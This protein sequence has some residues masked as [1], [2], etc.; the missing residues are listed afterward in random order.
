MK[1][2]EFNKEEFLKSEL[3]IEVIQC[4]QALETAIASDDKEDRHYYLGKWRAYQDMLKY[5]YGVYYSFTRMDEYFGAV[6]EDESDWLFKVKRK[7]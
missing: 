4:C 2:M 6:T 3:G 1:T 5:I 7:L